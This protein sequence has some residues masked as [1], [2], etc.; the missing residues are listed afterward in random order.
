VLEVTGTGTDGRVVGA[1]TADG[2][3][4][5]NGTVTSFAVKAGE[6]PEVGNFI[7]TCTDDEVNDTI[8]VGAAAA[9]GGNTGDGTVTAQAASTVG[10]PAKLGTWTL[11]CIEAIVNSGRFRLTDPE[12]V[13]VANDILIPAGAGNTVVWDGAGI[14]FTITDGGT[15]FAEGDLWTIAVS[16]TH[17]GKFKLADPN[18]VVIKDD[19][20]L[21]GTTGGT[22]AVDSGGIT[23]TLTDGATDF[24]T[25]DF[26][27]L[28]IAAAEGGG[29]KLT[30]PGGNDIVTGLTLPGTAGGAATFE[31]AGM[32]F[33]ITD[34]STDFATGDL[35]TVTVTAGTQWVPFDPDAVNGG[36]IPRGILFIDDVTAAALVA[37]TVTDQTILVGGCCTVDSSQIV[38]DDGVSTLD[39]VLSGGDTVRE[40]LAKNGIFAES[41]VDIAGYENA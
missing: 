13:E 18:G 21:P 23:F 37:G 14:T 4:T 7:L 26:F 10:A 34:G 20:L 1:V 29:F 31:Y 25:D 39:T 5:G 35:F 40:V 16:G 11:D 30:D 15:D 6:T 41:T 3:N 12:G 22:I 19:I 24:A 17:G 27:T 38:F 9:D 28:A 8:V 32:T 33:T 36:Q 2:G